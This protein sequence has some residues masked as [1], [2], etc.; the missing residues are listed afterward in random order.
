MHLFSLPRAQVQ[1]KASQQTHGAEQ[2]PVLAWKGSASRPAAPRNTRDFLPQPPL[3]PAR[4]LSAGLP[5]PLCTCGGH[6]L[7]LALLAGIRIHAVGCWSDVHSRSPV[8]GAARGRRP[9]SGDRGALGTGSRAAAALAARAGQCAAA[10]G[11]RLRRGERR[12]RPAPRAPP[13]VARA[14]GERRAEG[15]GARGESGEGEGR[16]ELG[17]A[18]ATGPLGSRRDLNTLGA[19][20]LL[21]PAPRA[22]RPRPEPWT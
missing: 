17:G 13:A 14:P 12:P 7:A 1:W 22:P 10:A 9:G 18:G 5:R 2:S 20:P 4:A 11:G 3:L 8:C 19:V 15:G 6:G 16:R 21:L